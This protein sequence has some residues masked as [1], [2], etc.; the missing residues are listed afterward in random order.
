MIITTFIIITSMFII[1]ITSM[2]IIT[3]VIII[4]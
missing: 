4:S 2:F 3:I 1:M